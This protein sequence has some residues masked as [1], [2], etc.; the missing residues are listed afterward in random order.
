MYV[1]DEVLVNHRTHMLI[2]ALAAMVGVQGI[3]IC[4]GAVRDRAF[5]YAGRSFVRDLRNRL[6][7]II[8][9]QS[10]SYLHRQRTG[11]L[12]SRVISDID[13]LQSSLRDTFAAL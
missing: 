3:A 5:E 6:F 2:P 11:D 10:V 9:R 8:N 4:L 1:V 13:I 7:R 12:I